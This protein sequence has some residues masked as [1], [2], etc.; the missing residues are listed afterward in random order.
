MSYSC[1]DDLNKF[2]TIKML[3]T[4]TGYGSLP[5][6]RVYFAGVRRQKGK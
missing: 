6:G 2:Y 5:G 4:Q 1:S 3:P